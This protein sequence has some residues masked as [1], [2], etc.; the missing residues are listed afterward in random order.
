M[1]STERASPRP[2]PITLAQ[3]RPRPVSGHVQRVR[4]ASGDRWRAKWR[5]AAGVEHLRVLDRVW[6]GKGRPAEGYLTKQ[7]AQRQ[8]DELLV[9]ARRE[10][11]GARR[12]AGR[13]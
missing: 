12:A 5:D 7:E 9:Q 2:T 13:G 3:L 4:R 1:S 10:G 8:L 11:P 6:T